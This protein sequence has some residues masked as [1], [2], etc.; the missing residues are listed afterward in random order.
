MPRVE[1][2]GVITRMNDI[3]FAMQIIQTLQKEY[4]VT[5]QKT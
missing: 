2:R 1:V 5:L 4:H 3:A